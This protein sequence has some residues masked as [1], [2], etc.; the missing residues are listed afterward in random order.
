[1]I[2]CQLLNSVPRGTDKTDLLSLLE[3]E[4]VIESCGGQAATRGLQG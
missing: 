4:L 3:R 2:C 1:M